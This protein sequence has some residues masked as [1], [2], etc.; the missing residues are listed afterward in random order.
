[1]ATIQSRRASRGV[2][3]IE[4][5]MAVLVFSIGLIGL[6]GLLVVATK[7]NQQAF[8]RT[9][10]TFLA[11]SMA[12]RM[13]ANPYGL[14]SGSYNA[15]YPVTGTMPK[16]DNTAACKP[17]DVALRDQ[18]L[19]SAQLQTFLPGL[20]PS[21]IACDTSGASFT[22]S[23]DQLAK[24]PPYSGI[25]TVTVTWAERGYGTTDDRSDSSNLQSFTWVFEP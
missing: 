2:S 22:P 8:T 6:A 10:L 25:C 12:D 7:S 1:V 4:V 17:S 5:L 3:L 13:R 21:T 9:Q 24:R 23:A 11:S 14:W 16:C 15:T 20:G 18:L 19:W